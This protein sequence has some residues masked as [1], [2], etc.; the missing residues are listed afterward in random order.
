ML[1]LVSFFLSFTGNAIKGAVIGGVT[2]AAGGMCTKGVCKASAAA[3][4]MEGKGIK[5]AGKFLVEKAVKHADLLG[6]VAEKTGNEALNY[7]VT[8]AEEKL[9][10]Q[11]EKKVIGKSV[12][13]AYLVTSQLYKH[14]PKTK[15]LVF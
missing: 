12:Q 6:K 4:K 9:Q 1:I 7:G 3:E 14:C 8:V 2:G 13:Y 11:P 5:K 10:T 15:L